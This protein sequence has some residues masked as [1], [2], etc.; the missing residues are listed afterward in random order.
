[1]DPQPPNRDW[2]TLI[3]TCIGIAVGLATAVST[4]LY[5]LF[6]RRAALPTIE[7][8]RPADW[9]RDQ[10]SLSVTLVIHNYSNDTMVA[11]QVEMLRPKGAMIGFWEGVAA[12][13]S[14]S[15]NHRVIHPSGSIQTFSPRLVIPPS[16]LDETTWNLQVLPPPGWTS[17]KLRMRL[18]TTTRSLKARNKR[19]A[20]NTFAMPPATTV[21]Q[22]NTKSPN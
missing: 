7:V 8:N 2:L 21:S 13:S 4:W 15:L 11:E 5:Y 6:I 20:I 10:K 19:W 14:L 1:M 16:R 9:S 12:S 3:L 22:A 18:V 17:G